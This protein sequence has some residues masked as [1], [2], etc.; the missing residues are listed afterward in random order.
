MVEITQESGDPTM[1]K[2]IGATSSIAITAAK[3][4]KI[5]KDNVPSPYHH[6]IDRVD[7]VIGTIDV[8]FRR[9]QLD[10]QQK[11]AADTY[12]D[13][14]DA[15]KATMGGNM[16]FDQVRA[17]TPTGTRRR[18]ACGRGCRSPPLRLMLRRGWSQALLG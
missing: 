15:L 8:M 18:A 12:R 6:G 5:T 1:P 7:R 13:A 17:G 11:R 4:R 3:A 2:K 14:F 16:D 10:N 9:R